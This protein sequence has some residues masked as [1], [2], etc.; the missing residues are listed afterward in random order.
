MSVMLDYISSMLMFGILAVTVARVQLNLNSTIS[1]NTFSVTTQQNCVELARQIEH[2]F[3]K[4][5]LHAPGQKVFFADSNKIAFKGD[6]GN[7]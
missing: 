6:L 3:L 7:S 4:I 5:G 2:D 1:Q